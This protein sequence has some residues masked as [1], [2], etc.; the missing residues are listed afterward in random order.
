MSLKQWLN[1]TLSKNKARENTGSVVSTLMWAAHVKLEQKDFGEARRLLLQALER[2]DEI[3]DAT[4]VYYIITSLGV[5]WLF[6]EEYVACIEF[7]SEYIR[8]YPGDAAAYCARGGA[9]WYSGRLTEALADHSRALEISPNDVGALLERGQILAETGE[10]NKA[11]DDLALALQLIPH[12]EIQ[13]ATWLRKMEAY[14]RNGR[15][16]ALGGIGEL[17]LAFREFESSIALCPDN[18]WVY[19]NRALVNDR[20]GDL[21]KANS[22]Y[23]SAL[24]RNDPKLNPLRR[25]FAEGRMQELRAQQ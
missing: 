4:Q 22:D 1:R 3:V 13:D 8:R 21:K 5:A 9:L 6:E 18:A 7:F 23:Q 15:G 12:G 24:T 10:H 17:E 19:F 14:A 25:K 11:L 2:R 16:L 20:L